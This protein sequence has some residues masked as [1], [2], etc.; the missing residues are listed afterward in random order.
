MLQRDGCDPDIIA[1]NGPAF[2]SQMYIHFRVPQR[3]LFGYVQDANR[4]L[5][6]ELR[7]LSRVLR[8]AISRSESAVQLT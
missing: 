2:P 4:R 6:Q 7:Q 3:G 1:R 8:P 5:T